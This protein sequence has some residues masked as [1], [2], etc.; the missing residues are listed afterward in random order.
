MTTTQTVASREQRATFLDCIDMLAQES[1]NLV[2]KWRQGAKPPKLTARSA[3]ARLAGS[4][5]TIKDS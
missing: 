5:R 3:R 2:V 4:G 1:K